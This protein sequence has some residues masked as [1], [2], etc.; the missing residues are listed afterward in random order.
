MVADFD[1]KPELIAGFRMQVGSRVF[2]GSLSGELD[3]LSRQI[4]IEQG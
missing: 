2:D 1:A 4:E 3:R